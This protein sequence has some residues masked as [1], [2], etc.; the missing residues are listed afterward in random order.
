MKKKWISKQTHS[1]QLAK[2]IKRITAKYKK[3]T[4]K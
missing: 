2:T 4:K 3:W 1:E